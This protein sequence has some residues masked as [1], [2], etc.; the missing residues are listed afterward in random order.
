MN[1]MVKKINSL[2]E[3]TN[4]FKQVNT[5]ILACYC[6]LNPPILSKVC[7]VLFN[8]I[9]HNKRY[10]SKKFSVSDAEEKRIYSN[11][12]LTPEIIMEHC[13]PSK[14]I[15][16]KCDNHKGNL[17]KILK[18]IDNNNIF[19][20]WRC[21]FPYVYMAIMERNIGSWKYYNENG[22]VLPKSLNKILE[23]GMGMMAEMH[24]M[25]DGKNQNVS[26]DDVE[27][28]FCKF[29]ERISSKMDDVVKDSFPKFSNQTTSEYMLTIK[30]FLKKH[31]DCQGLIYSDAF[32]KNLP[33][34]IINKLNGKDNEM[35]S[36]VLD[37]IVPKDGNLVTKKK[38][39]A[40]KKIIK[41]NVNAPILMTFD[42]GMEPFESPKNMCRFYC[43]LVTTKHPSAK[44]YAVGHESVQ[45]ALLM[46]MLLSSGHGMDKKFLISWIKF[47]ID[48]KLKGENS[49]NRDKTSIKNLIST[50]N[51]Y[52]S[53]Y[54]SL[55][56]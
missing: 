36:Y 8:S 2:T 1:D 16:G 26:M 44:F 21:G 34:C 54:V 45:A 11:V 30:N 15:D 7:H 4:N 43:S 50:F 14:Y 31:D 41:K 9:I 6:G 3:H 5:N 24:K 25:L 48:L 40:T 12:V 56:I 33:P 53:K 18:E 35:Y 52:N 19:Y 37:D 10:A 47:F 20:I 55:S 22:L 13:N 29:I 38:E 17:V 39:K 51:L 28:S 46:D 23:N 42:D 32:V 27:K 49:L